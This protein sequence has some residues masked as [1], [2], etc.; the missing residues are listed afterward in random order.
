MKQTNNAIKFLMAQY[1]AIFKNAYFKSMASA[2]VIALGMSMAAAP[3]NAAYE[4]NG[5]LDLDDFSN[6]GRGGVHSHTETISGVTQTVDLDHK[7][8]A[9]L[10]L[11]GSY[12][13][14]G[15]LN[16]ING[17]GLTIEGTASKTLGMRGIN[18]D[19]GS[20]FVLRNSSKTNTSI[21]GYK[22]NG[23][24]GVD[25]DG[26]WGSFNITNKSQA[27]IENSGIEMNDLT[28]TGSSSM[29]IGGLK[30]LDYEYATT[31][32]VGVGNNAND[33]FAKWTE[34]AH[35]WANGANGNTITDSTLN[36]NNYSYLATSSKT[37]ITGASVINFNGSLLDFSD[38]ARKTSQNKDPEG[39]NYASAFLYGNSASTEIKIDAT[40]DEKKPTEIVAKPTL[41]V[42]DN[43]YGAIYAKKLVIN[44]AD[45]NIGNG[46]T[47]ILDGNFTGK[48]VADAGK[49][50]KTDIRLKNVKFNNNGTLVIADGSAASANEDASTVNVT[51]KTDMQG[52][53]KNYANV[54]VSNNGT[55]N[56][57][58]LIISENQIL[59]QT[60]SEGKKIPTGL[61]AGSNYVKLQ[62]TS[63]GILEVVGTDADGLD[64]NK[65]VLFVSDNNAA[66]KD[67]A[68]RIE[69]SGAGTIKGEHLVLGKAINVG[70]KNKLT[71]DGDILE[72]GAADTRS[73]SIAG[74]GIEAAKAHDRVILNSSGDVFTVDKPLTLSRDFYT[75]DADGNYTTTSNGVGT[76]EG[77][78]IKL[79][80][81]GE[82]K[83]EG[84]AFENKGQALNLQSGSLTVGAV[85]NYDAD[86][87]G[88]GGEQAD[89]S[90]GKD[91]VGPDWKYYKNANPASLTWTGK[92][93]IAG[94]SAS[95]VPTISV[96]GASGANATLDLTRANVTWGNGDITLSGAGVDDSGDPSHSSATD[97]FAR[98]G[99]G[100][101]TITGNQ[102]LDYLDLEEDNPE[103]TTDTSITLQNGGVLLVQGGVTSPINFNKFEG[104]QAV[105][106]A[107]NGHVN[108][109]GGGRLV[110]TGELGLV[111]GV[112]EGV[113]DY[114]ISSLNLAEGSIIAQGISI[115]N[116]APNL[117]ADED[118]VEV[119][120]STGALAVA[121]R[122]STSNKEIRFTGA[123]LVLDT[124]G[125]T[126]YGLSASDSGL[127]DA[128][129]LTFNGSTSDFE[130]NTGKWTIGVNGTLGDVDLTEGAILSVG[131][132]REEY[133]RN[134]ITASLTLDNLSLA[135]AADEGDP[136][137]AIQN[138]AEL[139]VNTMQ[140]AGTEITVNNGTLVINGRSAD[141]TNFDEAS[142]PETLVDLVDSTDGLTQAGISLDEASI[143][144][145][146]QG[147][148]V[149]GD[150]AAKAL[151]QFSKTPAT[152]TDIVE[153]ND[154]LASATINL[155]NGSEFKLDFV[156]G[157]DDASAPEVNGG[158]GLTAEQAA[159]LKTK[160][161]D[162]LERG[163]FINV[164]G[165]ALD[166][167]YDKETMTAQWSDLKDFMQIESA[168]VNNDIKQILVQ[169]IGST[170]YIAGQFGAVESNVVGDNFIHVDGDLGLHKAR[171]GYFASVVGTD[172][173]RKAIGLDLTQYSYL[174]LAGEGTVGTLQSTGTNTS[175][176]VVFAEGEFIPGAAT[177]EGDIKNIGTLTVN[178][179]VTVTGNVNVGSA[180]VNKALSAKNV[181]LDGETGSS[182]VTGTMNVT[183]TL[184]IGKATHQSAL[185]VANGAVTT[186]N[187][188]LVNGSTLQVGFKATDN[189][190]DTDFN[191]AA[192]YTGSL[193][194]QT[195]D[196]GNGGVMVD[197]VN[198]LQTAFVSFNKFKDASKAQKSMDLGTIN[199]SMYVGN[200]SSTALCT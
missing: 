111:T 85:F 144:V 1:R 18:V 183:D 139:N 200:N 31:N 141:V 5:V 24:S 131:A 116:I 160:L 154:T 125:F 67:K 92:F 126:R 122:L 75:K 115:N 180:V 60:N 38:E 136:N 134:G 129:K 100:V 95:N 14:T 190:P 6:S 33:P 49:H 172:G 12:S 42:L 159:M 90:D 80:Q 55:A 88:T 72:L 143:D 94:T 167:K 36:L 142:E 145:S 175:S 17:A 178:N 56:L 11:S 71:L 184:Q 25:T 138:G 173:Q 123:S 162:N 146:N 179:D 150:T 53:L 26:S 199:G 187:L 15:T 107:T 186:Q 28:L 73:A 137:L 46:A 34:F 197:P 23:S 176:E 79:V 105:N 63:G 41:N 65:D 20:S 39:L 93:N 135:G 59:Q 165:L 198:E 97:Y 3:A 77:D 19:N 101:L 2:A 193:A 185:T 40:Y 48:K 133:V 152:G 113:D 181:T 86:G 7:D 43:A 84:G 195:V 174:Q 104:N 121:S 156:K 96:N 64:L 99:E 50:L 61:F 21:L 44:E 112:R 153:V 188:V 70:A 54:I 30:E 168:V 47:F 102:F 57:G 171:E 16:L 169:G 89:T 164:G 109:S 132:D 194:A 124:N 68:G 22:G 148:L 62:G 27:L 108:F 4:A 182:L 98:G 192:N 177:V 140:A 10:P 45:I 106:A 155:S 189:D 110:S 37:T 51:G 78:D 127:V 35:F 83:V 147:H 196:L 118:F 128:A 117:E 66:E 114:D 82:I 130:V 87:N 29:T 161:V 119:S 9:T 69:V 76:I 74:L 8:W 103:H 81:D 58:H 120:G 32:T 166:M 163:S 170:D 158:Q 157:E 151:V 13:Y 91:G 52:Q 191:E 149:L